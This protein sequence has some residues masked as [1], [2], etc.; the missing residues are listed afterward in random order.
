MLDVLKVKKCKRDVVKVLKYVLRVRALTSEPADLRVHSTFTTV[1][2][3]T[4]SD[5]LTAENLTG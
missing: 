5:S 3:I 4:A 2:A 1:D